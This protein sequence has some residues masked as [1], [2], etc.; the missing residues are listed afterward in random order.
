MHAAVAPI[1]WRRAGTARHAPNGRTRRPSPSA[2]AGRRCNCR[3]G[4]GANPP[5][6]C[7]I[8][9]RISAASSGPTR[10]SAS[11][12]RTQSPRQAAIPALRRSPSRS[13]APSMMRSVNRRAISGERVVAA[14]EHDDDLVG[15]AEAGQAVGELMPL[16][17]A[18]RRERKGEVCRRAP[19]GHSRLFDRGNGHAASLDRAPPE[20]PSPPP[21]PPRP[22]GCP[23][24]YRSCGDRIRAEQSFARRRG[25]APPRCSVP[26]ARIARPGSV[27]TVRGSA[28]PRQR[29]CASAR[30][31]CR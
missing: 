5:A 28:Y 2:P 29:R 27:R 24:A 3:P 9:A 25:C 10:S 30:Y 12:S 1:A 31:R 11:I 17:C 7:A 14:V 13:Q 26:R 22:T 23:S 6:S 8:T 18:R 15:E 19:S 21:R 4:S 16:R 20:P